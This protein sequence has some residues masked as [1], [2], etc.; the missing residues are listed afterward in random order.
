MKVQDAEK[1]VAEKSNDELLTILAHRDEWQLMILDAAASQLQKRGVQCSATVATHTSGSKTEAQ[2]LPRVA[3]VLAIVALGCLALPLIITFSGIY[4]EGLGLFIALGLLATI[5][6]AVTILIASQK[7]QR[8]KKE[9]SDE[10]NMA[11]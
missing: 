5:A 10:N 11:S 3:T 6:S 9:Q 8:K 1:I 4:I 7:R 2:S